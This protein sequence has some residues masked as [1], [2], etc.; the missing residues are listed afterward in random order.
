[1]S[2]T[3]KGHS[4]PAYGQVGGGELKIMKHLRIKWSIGSE[5][6]RCEEFCGDSSLV[7][8]LA[9]VSCPECLKEEIISL[10]EEVDTL[11]KEL[12][13]ATQYRKAIADE[14]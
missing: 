2:E 1:M 11:R 6:N 14:F 13:L 9:D 8:E 3:T 12:G 4:P 5:G 7:Q 10:R